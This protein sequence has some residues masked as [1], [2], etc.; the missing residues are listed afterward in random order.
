MNPFFAV[1]AI[2]ESANMELVGTVFATFSIV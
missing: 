2:P 1:T